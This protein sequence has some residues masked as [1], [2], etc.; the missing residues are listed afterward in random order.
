MSAN[1]SH[2]AKGKQPF[3]VSVS[4]SRAA[5]AHARRAARH[6]SRAVENG[7]RKATRFADRRRKR[8]RVLLSLTALCAMELAASLF[9]S[10]T[11]NVRRSHIDGGSN[12]AS[13]TATELELTRRAAALPAGTNWLLA[14][15]SR[16]QSKLSALPWVRSAQVRRHF[17]LEVR[18]IVAVRRPCYALI[19]P[20]DRYEVDDNN[21][22][23]R[24]LRPQMEQSL[25]AV[26]LSEPVPA[27]VGVEIESAA[28]RTAAQI[29]QRTQMDAAMRCAKIEVDQS[30]NIWLNMSTGVRIKF[31]DCSA[32]DAKISMMKRLLSN[33]RGMQFSEINVSSPEWPAGRLRDTSK[34]GGHRVVASAH[35][36]N[37]QPDTIGDVITATNRTTS[38]TH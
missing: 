27:R 7:H 36:P 24:A 15:V 1:D 4:A 18:A 23:I 35:A 37:R 26:Y 29:L 34:S 38:R 19:M 31:G 20:S 2:S 10:P 5:S 17:P 16:V 9:T 25:P 22:P 28:I 6:G 21:T 32:I 3:P 13:L 12:M 11:I 8:G 14:P 30:T 33:G